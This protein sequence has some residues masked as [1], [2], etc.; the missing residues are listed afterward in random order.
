MPELR[1]FVSSWLNGL[2]GLPRSG[3]SDPSEARR[4]APALHSELPE[5]RHSGMLLRSAPPA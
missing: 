1:D 4:Q 2:R 5:F 3:L